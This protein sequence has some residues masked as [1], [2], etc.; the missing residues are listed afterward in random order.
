MITGFNEGKVPDAIVGDAY[1]PNQARAALGLRDNDD[2]LA[3]D[4]YYLTALLESRAAE[5]RVDLLVGKTAN[6]HSPL[7]PSRLLFLCPDEELPTRARQLF[8]GELEDTKPPP[9]PWSRAWQLEPPPLPEDAKIRRQ[10]SVTQFS[11]YLRC[12]FRFFLKHGLGMEEYDR[13]KLEMDNRDFGNLCHDALESFGSEP[14]IRNSTDRREISDYLIG[15]LGSRVNRIY[16]SSLTVPILIQLESAK[17]RLDWAARIQAEE[18]A[19]GWAI[20]DVE[21]SVPKDAATDLPQWRIAGLPISFKIDRIERHETT[22]ELRVLDYK[23]S[24]RATSPHDTHLARIPWGVELSEF[25]DWALARGSDGRPRR[26]V[27]LQLPLYIQ[28]LR[29]H[30]PDAADTNITTGLFKLPRAAS[31]TKIDLWHNLDAGTLASALN[32]AVRVVENIQAQNFWPPTPTR[33]FPKW[34]PFK[35]L[36]FEDP[37]AAVKALAD[38]ATP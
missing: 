20:T 2:R 11:D 25:P 29:D 5:G 10:L 21:W 22:G 18:R 23:T 34:D 32:C 12:P 19:Y 15:Q 6:D 28:A 8:K 14:S 30:Y 24:D 1:L 33:Q 37:L 13:H 31:E 27:N 16:G 4:I 3:R 36:F 7:S 17:Q 35:K 26:W 38:A 9:A